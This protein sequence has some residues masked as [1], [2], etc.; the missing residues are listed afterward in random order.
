MAVQV[1]RPYGHAYDLGVFTVV[2]AL[3]ITW[4]I[5][6]FQTTRQWDKIEQL[7]FKMAHPWPLFRLFLVFSN[8]NYNFYNK[9]M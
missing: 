9:Y 1:V 7:F 8:K 6:A 4:V 2:V 5:A 3:G